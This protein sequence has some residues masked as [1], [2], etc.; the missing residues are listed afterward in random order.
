MNYLNV[1]T[2]TW[3]ISDCWDRDEEQKT[4]GQVGTEMDR[5]HFQQLQ[6][7]QHA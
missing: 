1:L 2:E 5:S 3:V 4:D 6:V 7:V